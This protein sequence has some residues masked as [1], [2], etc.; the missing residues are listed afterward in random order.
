M[1]TFRN[2]NLEILAHVKYDSQLICLK[3]VKTNVNI[4][5]LTIKH[6][7]FCLCIAHELWKLVEHG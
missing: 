3:A 1:N 7:S 5:G 2:S 6:N 4:T